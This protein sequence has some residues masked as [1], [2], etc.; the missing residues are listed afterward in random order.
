MYGLG[1]PYYFGFLMT[2]ALFW[3]HRNNYSE[4]NKSC[5]LDIC[6]MEESIQN[7]ASAKPNSRMRIVNIG[8]E[9]GSSQISRHSLTSNERKS[10]PR[11]EGA[12]IFSNYTDHSPIIYNLK[13]LVAGG[14]DVIRLYYGGSD[15]RLTAH[16]KILL[17]LQE[18]SFKREVE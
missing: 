6:R 3:L 5:L 10:G 11:R 7:L 15:I 17:K 16:A 14:Y 2:S 13:E 4:D 18:N 9:V 8:L 1:V 12:F